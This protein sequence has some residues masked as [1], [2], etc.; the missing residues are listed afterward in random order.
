MTEEKWEEE[1]IEYWNNRLESK[2][3]NYTYEIHQAY[4]QACRKRQEENKKEIKGLREELGYA[5]H[6]FICSGL[7]FDHPTIVKLSKAMEAK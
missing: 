3:G 1:A 4:L 5:I 6:E 2:R 7:W